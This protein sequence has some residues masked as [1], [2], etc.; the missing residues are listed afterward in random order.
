MRTR[1]DNDMNSIPPN[2]SPSVPLADIAEESAILWKG[3]HSM[4]AEDDGHSHLM[5]GP[6]GMRG[7]TP[8]PMARDPSPTQA[9][10]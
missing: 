1:K 8:P 2:T 5:I 6:Y 10:T 7:G 9:K 3:D 4:L